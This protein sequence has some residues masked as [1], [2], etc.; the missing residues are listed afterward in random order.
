MSINILGSKYCWN[1]WNSFIFTTIFKKVFFSLEMFASFSLNFIS[2]L[3]QLKIAGHTIPDSLP[4]H[5]IPPRYFFHPPPSLKLSQIPPRYLPSNFF[6]PPPTPPH[7]GWVKQGHCN[8]LSGTK[9]E[10]LRLGVWMAS[11][12]RC[13]ENITSN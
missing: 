13:Q 1:V 9:L 4:A 7:L 6:H 11:K 5:L 12:N 8:L 10:W 3:F 2:Q